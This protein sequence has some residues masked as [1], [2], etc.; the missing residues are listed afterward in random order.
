M[1]TTENKK[2]ELLHVSLFVLISLIFFIKV[3]SSGGTLFGGDFV[4][5]FFPL[6][7]FIRN[8]LLTHGS[9]PFWNPFLFSGTPLLANIQGSMFY[10]LGFLYYLLPSDSAYVY[11]TI[12]HFIL[13]C[14][15]MY[16]LMRGLSVSLA[17]SFMS[18]IIFIFNGYFMGHVYAGHLTFVQTYIWIPLIFLFLYR[19]FQSMDFKNAVITGLLLGVQ[20]LGGFP[21]LAFIPSWEYCSLVSTR[22]YIF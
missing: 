7:T 2:W 17:G 16:L 20:I 14:C 6:K 21:Q 8:H 1:I 22:A 11:S 3:L 12:L 18:A 15:F 19:F 10:P 13:G 5:Y 9:L 4:T